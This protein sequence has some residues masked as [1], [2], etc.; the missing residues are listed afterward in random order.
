M[1]GSPASLGASP[2]GPVP[3]PR[4]AADAHA[5]L[6]TSARHVNAFLDAA[7]PPADRGPGRLHEA[8]RYSVFA[9]GKRLRP[10][11]A[12]A[13][14][15]AVG[16]HAEDALAYAAALEM[17]HTYSL[18]HDDLPAMDDDALRRGK[19]TSHVVFGEALAI[20]AADALHTLAFETIASHVTSGDLA[21]AL[22]LDLSKAAGV[23]GMV[24]GQVEDLDAEGAPPSEERL[25][26]IHA[27]KTAALIAAACEGGGRCA[28]AKPPHL[29]ALA[30][31]GQRLGLAFQ[32]VDDVLDETGT[33]ATLGKTPGKDKRVVKQTYVAL[34]GADAARARAVGLVAQAVGALTPLPSTALLDALA[35]FVVTRDR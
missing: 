31:Y 11:L 21:R 4:A 25:A 24:G 26:R 23:T 7:L 2:S 30:E 12:M 1:P 10:A 6:E 20:L 27:E 13:A 17:V 3:G 33:A 19:P 28:G 32:I 34:E 35:R 18:V 29:R 9:G 8:M 16:G 15:E 5:F 22:V 14:A